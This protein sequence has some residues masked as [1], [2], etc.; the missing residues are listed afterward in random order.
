MT[1]RSARRA[2]RRK[3][4]Y[5][6]LGSESKLRVGSCMFHADYGW[7]GPPA[8]LLSTKGSRRNRYAPTIYC[9]S[10][11]ARRAGGDSKPLVESWRRQYAQNRSRGGDSKPSPYD[12]KRVGVSD[13]IRTRDVQIHSLALYQA[14]LRSPQGW[15]RAGLRLSLCNIR[16]RR[17]S[18]NP[19][20][21]SIL[22]AIV[23]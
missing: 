4:R 20:A 14:E 10:M 2:K 22:T 21:G 8:C 1:F 23:M 3:R 5:L 13:G 9:T 6:R 16:R 11:I 12:G 17:V 7:Y 18:M 15:N 19:S